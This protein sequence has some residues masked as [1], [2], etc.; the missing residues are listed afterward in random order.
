MAVAKPTEQI[1]CDKGHP[2]THMKLKERF[3]RGRTGKNVKTCNICEVVIDRKSPRWRCEERCKFNCCQDCYDKKMFNNV[4]D[5]SGGHEEYKDDQGG[6]DRTMTALGV[7]PLIAN[8]AGQDMSDDSDGDGEEADAK[9]G[10]FKALCCC[11]KSRPPDQKEYE[12][13]DRES[14]SRGLMSTQGSQCLLDEDE[15]VSEEES[16]EVLDRGSI[17]RSKTS[18][19]F[20]S[21]KSAPAIGGLELAQ[22]HSEFLLPPE[23]V[24]F[25]PSVEDLGRPAQ[26]EGEAGKR[27]IFKNTRLTK[28]E[29]DGLK[30]LH[31]ELAAEAKLTKE[32]DDGFPLYVGLH[33]LRILQQA[34]FDTKKALAIILTHLNMRVKAFPLKDESLAEDL[35]KGLMYWHGRDRNG[36]PCLVW[37]M[38]RL[39]QPTGSEFSKDTAIKL[40]LFVLEYAVR[41]LMAPGRVENWILIVDLENVG[42]GHSSSANRE[43]AKNISILL[44]QV[45]CGR[46]F[47][48]KILSLPWVVKSI[49]N[50]FIPADKKE[51]VQF[52]GASELESVMGKLFEPHQLEK[53]Y[54]GTSPNVLPEETY[55]FKF[56]PNCTGK[57]AD[58]DDKSLHM[59]TDRAFHEGYLWDESTEVAKEKW[60]PKV[61]SQSLTSAACEDLESLGIQNAKACKDIKSWLERVN[62]EELLRRNDES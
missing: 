57:A 24:L 55:P 60:V 22:P 31:E 7:L 8:L 39:V 37:S 32:G 29:L 2:V 14:S 15:E 36:R 1:M 11:L 51:K 59:F 12:Q 3:F 26:A 43:I 42:L 18:D 52:V 46:N 38:A 4:K 23:V 20:K 49:V 34:K 45:Y 58:G 21:T 61:Q 9:G 41:Y 47:Q 19:L 44:E 13:V 53:K 6:R 33:A 28:R 27:M 40:V 17:K 54:G 5:A 10:L 35:R 56:F 50:G 48:T 25:E 30:T 62:P 16:S